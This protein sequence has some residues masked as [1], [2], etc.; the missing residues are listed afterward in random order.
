MSSNGSRDD[1]FC[2]YD[3]DVSRDERDT[4]GPLKE[5]APHQHEALT[6][7]AAW[8]TSPPPSPAAR[9]GILVL[10]TGGGKTFTATHFLCRHPL[11]QGYRV[12]WLAHTHHLLDQ[13]AAAFADVA[14]LIEPPRERLGVRVVSGEIQHFPISSIKES[15][16]VVVATLQTVANGLGKA[17]PALDAFLEAAG[18]KLFVVFDEAHHSPAPTYRRLLHTLRERNRGMFLLGLT[19]TPTHTDE[20]K[21][22]WLTDLF[23]QG[24]LHQVTT[25]RLI[26]SPCRS[27]CPRGSS[28]ISTMRPT[29]SGSAPTATSPRRSWRGW[30]RAKAAMS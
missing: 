10:P 30:P 29:A 6:R 4:G 7:L 15:D 3:L 20:R 28:R 14:G 16:D 9:G 18:E 17:H 5:P 23:P 22:G 1:A 12:L 25:G 13:A 19:A 8:F 24:I 11:S 2:E 26:R 27:R 21:R